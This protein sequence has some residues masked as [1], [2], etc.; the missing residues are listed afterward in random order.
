MTRGKSIL[1][2]LFVFFI[3]CKSSGGQRISSTT[4]TQSN[5]GLQFLT[6][7]AQDLQKSF[8][9]VTDCA[10]FQQT[11]NDLPGTENCSVGGSQ[12]TALSQSACT[13]TP[14]FNGQAQLNITFQNCQDPG[15][16]IGGAVQMTF[17]WDGSVLTN[18]TQSS[19]FTFN[20]LFYS[21]QDLNIEVD[22]M[23]VATCSGVLLIQ[24]SLCG[25]NSD[26]NFCAL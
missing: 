23:N 8:S 6:A 10:A 7:L 26:C 1:V 13:D 11:L 25:V 14:T 3:A 16:A 21:I 22:S 18:Q 20:G 9:G 5:Q 17:D 4:Q 15:Q 19:N 24:G 2:L 12:T